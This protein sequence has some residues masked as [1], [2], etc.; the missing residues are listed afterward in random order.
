MKISS[1]HNLQQVFWSAL[2]VLVF[3][4]QSLSA[5]ALPCTMMAEQHGESVG[6]SIDPHAGHAMASEQAAHDGSPCCEGATYCSMADCLASPALVSPV[7]APVIGRLG[8]PDTPL[9]AASIEAA[10]DLLFRPPI[11]G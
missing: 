1:D 5:L 7:F 4:A 6:A 11:S 2:L 10:P 8:L 3:S 9:R